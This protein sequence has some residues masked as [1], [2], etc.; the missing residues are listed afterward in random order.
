VVVGGSPDSRGVVASASY[1]ARRFGVRSAMPMRTALQRCP[2]ATRVRPHFDRYTQVSRQLMAI[3]RELSDLVEP[4]SLDEA[5]LDATGAVA[6]G[7]PPGEIAAELRSRVRAELGLTISVGVATSKSVAKIASDMDKP[8][9]LT[10]VPP[11]AERAFLAPL[12]IEKLWGI[13]PKTAVRLRREGIGTIAELAARPPE[14]WATRFGKTGPH[15]RHLA[16]GED[17]SPVVE[18]RERKSVSAETTLAEDT[19]DPG[20]LEELTDRLSQSVSR[21]LKR[22]EL[23]GRTVK[24][25]LRL[26]DFTTFTRQVTMPRPV[27][28]PKDIAQAARTMLR[29]ELQSGRQF[30]LVG[31][32]VS[33]FQRSEDQPTQ[34]RLAG[35]E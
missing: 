8:D 5:Y 20:V 12:A 31:V 24:L 15:L 13:G 28:A 32:G 27:D 11:G 26:S 30:R 3:L 33:S 10:I 17:D 7:R 1:E 4:L 21:H 25:K 29:R 34:P 16:L 9:G 14:W 22:A 23:R 2:Q 19:G 35:F 6:S 18:H